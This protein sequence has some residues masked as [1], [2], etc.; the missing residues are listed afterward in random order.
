MPGA[1]KSTVTRLV[2]GRLPRSV[3]LDDDVNEMIVNG[4]VYAQGEPTAEAERQVLLSSRNLCALA[5][6]FADYVNRA[7][8][9]QSNCLQAVNGMQA[10]PFLFGLSFS[11][12]PVSAGRNL[13][14]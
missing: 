7:L 1:G 2:A 5:D 8:L 14:R 12:S 10:A 13:R 3:R 6:N 9:V 11:M 4:D